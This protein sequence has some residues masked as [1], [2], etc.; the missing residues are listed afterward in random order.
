M[1]T[2]CPECRTT[3]RLS[4]EQL[5]ARRGQVRC[6]RCR[7]VFDAGAS[8]VPD[9]TE[10]APPPRYQAAVR[11]DAAAVTR[12]AAARPGPVPGTFTLFGRGHDTRQPIKVG[13]T[14]LMAELP[15]RPAGKMARGNGR[16]RGTLDLLLAVVLALVLVAQAVYFL[17]G[18]LASWLP[19]LRPAL[20]AACHPL[21][22]TVPLL[23][24]VRAVR[25]EASALET[26]PVAAGKATLRVAFSNRSGQLQPWPH[27]VLKLT[28]VRGG[29]L[30]QRAFAPV[31]Y[32]G[33]AGAV[34][35]G[36]APESEHEFSLALDLGGLK[37]AGYAVTAAYP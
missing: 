34:Q 27:L 22:C 9:P 28:D 35:A 13:D 2:T 33:K 16:R 12:W 24:D 3:F 1:L 20:A 5:D 31:D 4:R 30:A 32:F 11:G 26:D 18:Q 15:S 23:G 36:I 21:G 6:G 25:I 8:L 29:V 7:A 10:T 19:A 14:I 37:A 17:R